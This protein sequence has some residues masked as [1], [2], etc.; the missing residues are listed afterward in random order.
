MKSLSPTQEQLT[1]EVQ[2]I[3]NGAHIFAPKEWLGEKVIL[4][5]TKKTLREEILSTL[6]PH[7][8]NIEGVYLYGSHA[9]K[10]ST[11]NSD[12]DLLVITTKPL[13]IKKHGY[14]IIALQKK[15]FVKAIKISPIMIYSIIQEAVPII[16][17]K[18]I[19]KLKSEHKPSKSEISKEIKKTKEILKI[20]QELLSKNKEKIIE[21]EGIAYSLI[22]R[23]KTTLIIS[24]LLSNKPYSNKTLSQLLK[25]NVNE[26]TKIYSSYISTKNSS[27]KTNTKIEVKKSSLEALIQLI[28][29]EIEK[30]KL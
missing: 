26:Y 5:R 10:E 23:L 20:N 27:R 3:G 22:L 14:E 13:K 11:I 9:R 12:I 30:V 8:E 25:N 29:K 18:L 1:R 19:E 15:E 16:N 7:L 2:Q 21:A 17:A 6:E 4:V 24:S 28:E